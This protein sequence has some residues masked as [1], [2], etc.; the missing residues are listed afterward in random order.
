MPELP[1]VETIKSAICQ[2]IGNCNIKDII[3]NNNR[4]RE[5]IPDDIGSK[6]CGAAILGYRRIAKYSSLT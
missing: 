4:L 6:I 2:S 3:V 5:K 1:E